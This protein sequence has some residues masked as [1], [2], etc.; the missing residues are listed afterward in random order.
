MSESV[1]K[2]CYSHD[3]ECFQD[4]CIHGYFNISENICKRCHN[5]CKSCNG[6]KRD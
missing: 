3:G 1:C 2:Y 4:S 5:T 6:L